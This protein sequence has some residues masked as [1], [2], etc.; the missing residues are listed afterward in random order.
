MNG[1]PKETSIKELFQSM[2]PR[3]VDL[4]QGTVTS[5]DP[6][7][8]QMVNDSKHIISKF[9]AVVPK[10]LTDY[11]LTINTINGDGVMIVKNAL[12]VGEKVHLLALQNGKKYF[13]LGRV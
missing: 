13:V 7:K 8:I 12:K 4:L 3:E 1:E 6:L 10:H 2:I 9:S 11:K 5:V